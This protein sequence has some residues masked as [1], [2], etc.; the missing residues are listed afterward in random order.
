[1]DVVEA[2]M[3]WLWRTHMDNCQIAETFPQVPYQEAMARYGSDKPDLRFQMIISQIHHRLP[4]DLISMLSPLKKPAID[5]LKIPASD[6]LL[7]TSRTRK[8]ITEFFDSPQGKPFMENVSGSPGVFFFDSARPLQGLQSFGFKAA[9]EVQKLLELED[10]D[11]LILQAR[12]DEPFSGGSTPMGDLRS[13]LHKE[14][15]DQKIL[16]PAR[17]FE[18]LWVTDF[19]LFSPTNHSEPG[20]GGTAG[21]SSTHHPFTSPKSAE[22]VDLLLKDPLRVVGDHYDLVVN[23]IELGGGSRRIHQAEMQRLVLE[24]VLKMPAERVAEFDHLLEA[25]RAGCPPHAGFALGIDRLL[26]LMTGNES[27]RDVI[28]FPKGKRGEDLMVRSPGRLSKEV[29]ETYHLLVREDS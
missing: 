22:D 27:V 29:L 17:G 18:F 5:V 16:E 9:E 11:L 28:A 13:A 7:E 2:L 12:P 14:A 20:Q 3:R 25:L 26:A 19:P 8:F 23:G 10:G 21:M 6:H 24:E 1:M 4:A 15:V